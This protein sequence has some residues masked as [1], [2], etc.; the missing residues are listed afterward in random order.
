VHLLTAT[1]E[2]IHPLSLASTFLDVG[3]V[4][5][6][7]VLVVAVGE[8]VVVEPQATWP[9]TITGTGAVAVAVAVAVAAATTTTG[10][11]KGGETEAGAV[12]E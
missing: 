6:V 5:V 12:F 10:T 1:G 3:T 2:E 8:R 9:V 11:V 4:L 7:A